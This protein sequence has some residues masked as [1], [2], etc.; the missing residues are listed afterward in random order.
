MQTFTATEFTACNLN[1][2][3]TNAE[4]ETLAWMAE[5]KENGAIGLLRGHGEPGAKKLV[6]S[7]LHKLDCNNRCL[8]IARAFANGYLKA[9]NSTLQTIAAL[10][11]IVSGIAAGSG[12]GDSF[13]RTASSRSQGT[14]RVRWEEVLPANHGGAA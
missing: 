5:G 6:S 8:A 14:Y 7:V 10:L 9:S 13:L 4:L 2:R 12:T 1:H 11:I 3:F